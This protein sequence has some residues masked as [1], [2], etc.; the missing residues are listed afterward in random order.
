MACAYRQ[1]GLSIQRR[2]CALGGKS[3]VLL[4]QGLPN[5]LKLAK[6]RL[7]RLI[8]KTLP[9][10][11]EVEGVAILDVPV[12]SPND[13]VRLLLEPIRPRRL[14][15]TDLLASD[16]LGPDDFTSALSAMG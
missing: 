1:P 10:L 5:A 9:F 15:E 11:V 12:H 7:L 8:F 13:P 2:T 16:R 14:I 6:R 3:L 4:P